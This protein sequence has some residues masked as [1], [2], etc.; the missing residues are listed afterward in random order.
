MSEPPPVELNVDFSGVYIILGGSVSDPH[1]S[2]SNVPLFV[3]IVVRTFCYEL[4]WGEIYIAKTKPYM[5][6]C[7]QHS[8]VV[9]YI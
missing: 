2:Y 5:Y 1:L 6:M 3:F 9:L 4:Y 7:I 8:T